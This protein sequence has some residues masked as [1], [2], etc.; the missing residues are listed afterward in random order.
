MTEVGNLKAQVFFKWEM[1]IH[2]R[3]NKDRRFLK[4][5]IIVKAPCQKLITMKK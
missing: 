5:M 3:C 2:C 1:G 4:S